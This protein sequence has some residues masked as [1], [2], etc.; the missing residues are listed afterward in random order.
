VVLQPTYHI[1]KKIPW[2]LELS[3][4]LD[5]ALLVSIFSKIFDIQILVRLIACV[6]FRM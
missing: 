1:W 6:V 4:W 3:Y 5:T 2:V